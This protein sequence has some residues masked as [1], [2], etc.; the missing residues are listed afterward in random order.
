MGSG[1]RDYTA[2]AGPHSSILLG[3]Q[4][5]GTSHL[6]LV[7]VLEGGEVLQELHAEAAPLFSLLVPASTEGEGRRTGMGRGGGQE[8]VD[9]GRRG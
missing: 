2:Y 3:W 8:E 1:S 5:A 4:H 6:L 7:A 9:E